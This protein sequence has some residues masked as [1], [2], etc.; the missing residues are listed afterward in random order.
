MQASRIVTG[1]VIAVSAQKK[2]QHRAGRSRV[3]EIY[4]VPNRPMLLLV[5]AVASPCVEENVQLATRIRITNAA[6][7]M[8]LFIG[9]FSFRFRRFADAARAFI[10]ANEE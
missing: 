5:A 9:R 4:F 8:A 6:R 2:A 1:C 10:S 3:S 7:Q